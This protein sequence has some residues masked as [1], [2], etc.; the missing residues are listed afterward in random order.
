MHRLVDRGLHLGG[1]AVFGQRQH[2]LR[3]ALGD[4]ERRAIRSAHRG[5]GALADRIKRLEVGDLVAALIAGSQAAQDGHIHRVVVFSARC[6]CCAEEKL[7][8]IAA[9]DDE[10]VAQRQL[11]LGQRAGLVRAKDIHARHFF[12][13][14]QPADHRLIFG[15]ELGAHSHRDRQ[16]RGHGHRHSS[17][18]QHQRELQGRQHVV[19]TEQGGREDQDHQAQ[20][21]HDQVVTDLQDRLLE[22]AGCVSRLDQTGS[23]AEI[24]LA[25]GG[26]DQRVA[27]ALFDH[28]A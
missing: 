10:R 23:S 6:Q 16:D 4:P 20:R 13:A 26:V 22:V 28:R 17:N 27:L 12:D 1:I 18:R 25:A 24:G 3:R 8:R 19:A 11:V 2:D 7:A 5:F 15:Q 9:L 21:Q 14:G